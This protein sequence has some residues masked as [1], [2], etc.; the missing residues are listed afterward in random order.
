MGSRFLDYSSRPESPRRAEESCGS[1]S[2]L[3]A[4]ANRGSASISSE[5]GKQG[6]EEANGGRKQVKQGRKE[7]KQ[8]KRKVK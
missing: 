1:R 3:L 5:G 7:V 6:R 8:G 2:E 4:V